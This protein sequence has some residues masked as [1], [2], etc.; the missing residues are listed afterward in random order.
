M[1]FCKRLECP[2]GQVTVF[3]MP[4]SCLK[5]KA[6]NFTPSDIYISIAPYNPN[7]TMRIASGMSDVVIDRDPSTGT[8]KT[9]RHFAVYAQDTGEVEIVCI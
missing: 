2:A 7:N 9:S 6:K 4:L 3:D 5:W 1:I 8:R